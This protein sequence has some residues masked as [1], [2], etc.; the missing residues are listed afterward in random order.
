M[1]VVWTI[2]MTEA[3]K[4]KLNRRQKKFVKNLARTNVIGKSALS[5]GYA[6]RTQGSHLL[7]EPKIQSALMVEMEKIG[8]HDEFL[9]K[10]LKHGLN[11]YYP[12]KKEGGKK[13]PD[14]FTRKQ[15]LD[16]ILKVRGDLKERK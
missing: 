9:A 14:F 12:P 16:S 7:R 13:Y 3:K 15:Y 4:D 2:Y 11:S 5:A 10:K 6:D 1:W 8:I